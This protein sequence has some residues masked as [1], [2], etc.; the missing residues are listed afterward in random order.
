[1]R[2]SHIYA[3]IVV[4]VLAVV[5]AV[6][7]AHDA[8]PPGKS[9]DVSSTSTGGNVEP[10]LPPQLA[11]STETPVAESA[12]AV[13]A[14]RQ[15]G[16]S[17]LLSS[18]GQVTAIDLTGCELDDSILHHLDDTPELT[19]LNL[20]GTSVGD[21]GLKHIH[22]L[23]LLRIL[24]LSRT[25]ITNNGLRHLQKLPGLTKLHLN[26]TEIS[27]E[28]MNSLTGMPELG[29]LY[30][31]GSMLSA[32]AQRIVQMHAPKCRIKR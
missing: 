25:N 4:A 11:E 14:F 26:D 27:D 6:W 3:L 23:P 24:R 31:M 15:L 28:G 17:V 1:M 7:F 29:R 16:G 5:S 32:D 2:T 10:A 13:R 19:L 12:D 21:E 18:T 30:G 9:P 22:D 8:S 20:D